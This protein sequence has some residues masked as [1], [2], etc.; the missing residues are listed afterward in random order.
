MCR[1]LVGAG[2]DVLVQIDHRL[3]HLGVRVGAPAP[4]LVGG[5]DLAVVLHPRQLQTRARAGDRCLGEVHIENHPTRPD[6]LAGFGGLGSCSLGG[7]AVGG[8]VGGALGGALISGE[9]Q[10]ELV[11]GELSG[12][13]RPA[14]IQR[15]VGAAGFELFGTGG[16]GGVEVEGIGEVEPSR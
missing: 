8:R 4:D 13:H 11:A 2:G 14:H 16:E 6:S 15:L 10:G 1:D 3:H 7:G 12:G 9:V 5:D